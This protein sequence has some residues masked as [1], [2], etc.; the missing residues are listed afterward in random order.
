[1]ITTRFSGFI[2]LLCSAAVV[3]QTASARTALAGG[4]P[5]PAVQRPGVPAQPS[6]VTTSNYYR[7]P[8]T[9]A[10]AP[11]VAG[12]GGR[13]AAGR[14]AIAAIAPQAQ[15][16]RVPQSFTPAAPM[17]V[18]AGPAQPAAVPPMPVAPPANKEEAIQVEFNRG[19]LTVVADNAELGKVLQLVGKR[20]GAQ[21]EVAPELSTEPVVAH[22]GPGSP[23]E[24]LSVL[25]NSPR[26]DFIIMGS[27]DQGT[28]QRL[29]VRRKS[30][31]ASE[32][33]GH[34]PHQ[35][36]QDAMDRH[37]AAVEAARKAREAEE[38]QQNSPENT[39]EAP[40]NQPEEAQ[41]PAPPQE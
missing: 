22:L 8:A 5:S 28:V 41:Q 13:G 27:D 38:E 10:P 26:I 14:V 4:K 29:L 20:T 11:D 35:Q 23:N 34:R 18:A 24:I 7:P 32:P 15:I 21:V 3:A 17:V 6:V 25:L 33:S 31:F 12:R 30:S 40:Q 1:M 2:L 39:T 36:P 16:A 19:L 9:A 37:N